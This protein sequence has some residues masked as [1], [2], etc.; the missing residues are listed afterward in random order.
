LGS[1][2]SDK[3]D[4]RDKKQDHSHGTG[5]AG[6]QDS[7]SVPAVDFRS[8]G[9]LGLILGLKALRFVPPGAATVEIVTDI[10]RADHWHFAPPRLGKLSIAQIF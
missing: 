10:R 5:D 9:K 7:A 8:C 6:Y 3:Q 4:Q 2:I 1:A